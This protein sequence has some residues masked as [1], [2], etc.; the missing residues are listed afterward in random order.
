[1][2]GCRHFMA[3][4]SSLASLTHIVLRL[5]FYYFTLQHQNS[6]AVFY[7]FQN[8]YKTSGQIWVLFSISNIAQ[9][10]FLVNTSNDWKLN[11]KYEEIWNWQNTLWNVRPW[12]FVN[13]IDP[14]KCT[15]LTWMISNYSYELI[16]FQ[17]IND[18]R[19]LY[20]SDLFAAH[21]CTL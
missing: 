5:L 21:S 7:S 1:M 19:V 13:E 8:T 10:S 20:I 17:G 4:V 6:R 12:G 9:R 15:K 2:L 11:T 18:S 3:C 16:I 14:Q